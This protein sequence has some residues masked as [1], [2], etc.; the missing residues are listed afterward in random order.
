VAHPEHITTASEN[1]PKGDDVRAA[2]PTQ[3]Q[4]GGDMTEIRP[5]RVETSDAAIDDLRERLA[6]TR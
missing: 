1:K 4:A 3:Q 2:P 5:F 6:R